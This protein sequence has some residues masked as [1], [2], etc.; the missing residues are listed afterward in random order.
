MPVHG[1]PVTMLFGAIIGNGNKVCANK[2]AVI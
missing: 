2:S 1:L